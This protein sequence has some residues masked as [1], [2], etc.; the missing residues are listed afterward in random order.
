MFHEIFQGFIDFRSKL[1]LLP[2]FQ[3]ASL[4]DIES[5]LAEFIV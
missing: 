3:H 1:D 4:G 2:G 5:E